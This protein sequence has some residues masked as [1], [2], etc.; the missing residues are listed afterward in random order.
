MFDEPT[1]KEILDA[2]RA[3]KGMLYIA[4]K[5]LGCDPKVVKDRIKYVAELK[6]AAHNE[7]ESTKDF[8][9]LK[10]I[11]ALQKGEPW[12]LKFFAERQ[13]R[14]RGYGDKTDITLNGAITIPFMPKRG[15]LAVVVPNQPP[16]LGPGEPAAS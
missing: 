13:M 9:E 5:K 11:E 6:E 14:D 1:D 2:I 16:L 4:A 8:V 3:S 12:A 15:D 7:K 10:L